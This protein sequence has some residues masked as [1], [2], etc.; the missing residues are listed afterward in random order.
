[1]L[2]GHWHNG[3]VFEREG[4]IW[5]VAPA[6]SWLPW[7]G[8]LGFALHSISADGKV[9]TRFVELPNAEP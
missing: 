8:Q 2:V 4:I 3:R 1:M 7:G 9:D 5:R 6:T